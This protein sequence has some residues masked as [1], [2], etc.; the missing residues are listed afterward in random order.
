MFGFVFPFPSPSCFK[1]KSS[2]VWINLVS[3]FFIFGFNRFLRRLNSF[4]LRFIYDD[5]DSSE[6]V[7]SIMPQQ[8]VLS[9]V[10]PNLVHTSYL[11]RL[12]HHFLQKKNYLLR[13]VILVSFKLYRRGTI[14]SK[15]IKNKNIRINRQIGRNGGRKKENKKAVSLTIYS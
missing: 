10:F 12:N 11:S 14:L 3:I 13:I 4:C 15:N 7:I 1:F 8:I 5:D 6:S 9:W 2:H